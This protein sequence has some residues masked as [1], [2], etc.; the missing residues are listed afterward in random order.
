MKNYRR[1]LRKAFWGVP[2][3]LSGCSGQMRSGELQTDLSIREVRSAVEDLKYRLNRYEVELQIAEG[4]TEAWNAS[5]NALRGEVARLNENES[6]FIEN[7]LAQYEKKLQ[8]LENTEQK[9]RSDLVKLKEHTHEILASLS[10]FKVKIDANETELAEQKNSVTYLRH[11]VEALMKTAESSLTAVYVVKAGD[12]LEKISKEHRI[13]V[14]R[15][16]D[17][18]RLTNDLIVVGQTLRLK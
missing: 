18:N 8:K 11:S 6:D 7:T 12:S 16:K 10:Q 14:E 15:I 2:L 17:L 4:K 5:M 9:I 13:S 1:Y 3:L